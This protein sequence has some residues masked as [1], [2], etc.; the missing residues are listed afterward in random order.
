MEY[1]VYKGVVFCVFCSLL[2]FLLEEGLISHAYILE[3]RKGNEGEWKREGKGGGGEEWGGEE[4]G[5]EGMGGKGRG[6]QKA[7]QGKEGWRKGGRVGGRE[8]RKRKIYK[9]QFASL[10]VLRYKIKC[11]IAFDGVPHACSLRVTDVSEIL[12]KK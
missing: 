4:R 9:L 5:R 12:Q 1:M 2:M 7:R 10:F 8:G 11:N 6:R 3:R